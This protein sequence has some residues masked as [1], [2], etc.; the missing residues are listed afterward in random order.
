MRFLSALCVSHLL[1]P[2][3]LGQDAAKSAADPSFTD[4]TSALGVRELSFIQR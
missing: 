3:L 1:I 4:V 2:T